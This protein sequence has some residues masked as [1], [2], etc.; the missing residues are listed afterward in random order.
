V[1]QLFV[2]FEAKK[3]LPEDLLKLKQK[4]E[5]IQDKVD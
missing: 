1:R 5:D 4:T 2:D 3:H